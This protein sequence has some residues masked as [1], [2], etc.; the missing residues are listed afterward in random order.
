MQTTLGC[1]VNYI[2]YYYT[3]SLLINRGRAESICTT[4]LHMLLIHI[5]FQ[6]IMFVYLSES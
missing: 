5:C 6:R 4:Y 3:Q 1:S 2:E